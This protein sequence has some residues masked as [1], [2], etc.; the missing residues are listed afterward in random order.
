MKFGCALS[1]L[2]GIFSLFYIIT[3]LS[4]WLLLVLLLTFFKMIIPVKRI[5][6]IIFFLMKWIYAFAVWCDDF[7]LMHILDIKLEVEGLRERYP[8]K[9][10]I[11][12]ANHQ[13]WND[14]FVLQHLF[15]RRAPVLKFLVKRE[16]IFLPIVGLICWAYDYPFLRRQ[17]IKGQKADPLHSRKDT[18]TL[19]RSLSSFSR[20]PASIINLVEG[21]RYSPEKA[22]IRT[23]PYR[24]LLKPKAGG[25]TT[26]LE[27][28][29]GRVNSIIDVTLVY[30]PIYPTFWN[31]LSGKCKKVYVNISEYAINDIFQ[32]CSFEAVDSWVNEIWA[33]KDAR[34]H[35]IRQHLKQDI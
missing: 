31:L 6:E 30:D 32:I 12:I 5:R 7:L 2:K 20:Y 4:F 1:H 13:S 34:I 17:S 11:I 35:T 18:M 28:L 9:F 19:A 16:L 21:T 8:E 10:Y 29:S 22:K 25:L 27:L 3:N 26:M 23:S 15:N 33:K 24:Y 14:I